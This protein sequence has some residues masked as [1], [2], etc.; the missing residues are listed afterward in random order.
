MLKLM[1]PALLL[2]AFIPNAA[3]AEQERHVAIHIAYHDLDLRNPAGVKQLDR[4][5]ER[6]VAEVCPDSNETDLARKLAVV[7][8]R[9]EKRADVAGQRARVLAYSTHRD[10]EMAAIRP[11]R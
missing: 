9:D 6:A 7:R 5:I 11:A 1:I 3:L 4:R 10:A 8:C 2:A